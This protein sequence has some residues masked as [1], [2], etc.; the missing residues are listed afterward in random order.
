MHKNLINFLSG[1]CGFWAFR[2]Q[3]LRNEMGYTEIPT[4]MDLRRIAVNTF[5][6]LYEVKKHRYV[7]AAIDGKKILEPDFN[8]DHFITRQRTDSISVESPVLESLAWYYNVDYLIL[9]P[10]STFGGN[11]RYGSLNEDYS[12]SEKPLFIF[13]LHGV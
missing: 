5:Q 2:C 11:I 4:I 3:M 9:S 12:T 1:N 6:Y 13:G 10:T 8:I 7:V